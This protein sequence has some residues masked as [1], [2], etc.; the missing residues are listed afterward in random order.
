MRTNESHPR[1]RLASAAFLFGVLAFSDVG[2]AALMV[3]VNIDLSGRL[4]QSPNIDINTD[5]VNP[6]TPE[7]L[8]M[9]DGSGAVEV[10]VT[11][12]PYQIENTSPSSFRYTAAIQL[13]LPGGY[14]VGT[15]VLQDFIGDGMGNVVPLHGPTEFVSTVGNQF[16]DL[17]FT[18][19]LPNPFPFPIQSYHIRLESD[20]LPA[21]VGG[22]FLKATG[23]GRVGERGNVPEPTSFLVWTSLS[24]LG[25]ARWR[26]RR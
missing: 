15:Y 8:F 21:D 4:G 1:F 6:N 25:I 26:R 5:P 23:F 10:W 20:V 11:F 16:P 7:A 14:P 19:N 22:L 9:T 13:D 24:V 3:P 2:S 12:A 18:E 17:S